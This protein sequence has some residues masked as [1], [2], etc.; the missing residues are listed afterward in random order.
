MQVNFA[1][2]EIHLQIKLVGI[3]L[4]GKTTNISHLPAHTPH[5]KVVQKGG[6]ID[7]GRKR[8]FHC[9]LQSRKA[10]NKIKHHNY[11]YIFTIHYVPATAHNSSRSTALHGADALI[12]IIDSDK[13]KLA[14]QQQEQTDTLQM[15]NNNDIP[16]VFQW[17]FRDS[18]AKEN[19][20]TLQQALNPQNYPAFLASAP[21][22][23]GVFPC[24]YTCIDQLTQKHIQQTPQFRSPIKEQQQ[25]QHKIISGNDYENCAFYLDTPQQVQNCSFYN[26]TFR[27]KTIFSKITNSFFIYCNFANL[28]IQNTEDSTAEFASVS[29]QHFANHTHNECTTFQLH[30][31]ITCLT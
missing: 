4:S 22:N 8:I 6:I 19:V 10:N 28:E 23:I 7:T 29:I 24:L 2:K 18:P 13:N 5:H 25:T 31:S 3:P 21:Q 11:K 15:L 30:S 16:Q 12:W 17:N 1:K 20:D 14:Q 27:D 26:C 9:K